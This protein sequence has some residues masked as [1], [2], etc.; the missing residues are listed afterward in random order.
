MWKKRSTWSNIFFLLLLIAMIIPQSRMV[1]QSNILRLTLR[2]PS[3][4]SQTNTLSSADLDYYFEDANG[5][6][7][8]LKE[9]SDKP[10]FLNYWATW[11]PPCVAEM[12]SIQKLYDD[13][14]DKVHFVVISNENTDVTEQFASKKEF[15]FPLS[16]GIAQT[17]EKL[18]SSSIPTTFI[19]SKKGE[20]LVAQTG[21][22]NWNHKKIRTLLD[23][24][25]SQ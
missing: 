1:I 22:N 17:P 9:L 5:N 13:Y 23:N 7:V 18:S 16:K 15:T 2:P 14:K 3:E 6:K 10:V 20:I 4:V 25:I 12:P 21:A 8:R 11:C 24:S 19:I